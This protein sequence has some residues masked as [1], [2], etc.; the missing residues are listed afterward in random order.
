MSS[1]HLPNLV[2]LNPC[3]T[4]DFLETIASSCFFFLALLSSCCFFFFFFLFSSFSFFFLA[5]TCSLCFFL[6][7][8]SF[9]A[10][11]STRGGF[12]TPGSC[13][14]RTDE[15]MY[16]MGGRAHGECWYCWTTMTE[17]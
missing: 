16:L 12:R 11:S 6:S 17:I 4:T 7:S 1:G 10:A 15:S 3:R 9:S 5:L 14:D 2:T 13:P 8:F